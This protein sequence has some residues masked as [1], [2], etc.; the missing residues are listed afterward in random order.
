V[1]DSKLAA[2]ASQSAQFKNTYNIMNGAGAQIDRKNLVAIQ[3][4][5]NKQMMMKKPGTSGGQRNQAS[6]ILAAS[7]TIDNTSAANRVSIPGQIQMNNPS[8]QIMV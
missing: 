8:Q 2:P 5:H 3:K 6:N 7:N 1:G 4:I